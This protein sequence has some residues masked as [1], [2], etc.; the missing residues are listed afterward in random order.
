MSQLTKVFRYDPK[1][2]SQ[3]ADALTRSGYQFK[4][5]AYAKF[6]ARG[7]GV[8]I[9][10]YNS[11]KVV[12]QGQ[13]PEQWALRYLGNA[14]EIVKKSSEDKAKSNGLLETSADQSSIGS[15]EAGKGDSFGGLVVSAV[16]LS[17]TE[18]LAIAKA[19]VGDSKELSDERIRVLAPWIRSN[20]DWAEAAL[21]PI[22]YNQQR[23][24]CSENVNRLLSK[25][26]SQLQSELHSKTGI[27]VSIVDRFSAAN[28]VTQQLRRTCPMVQVIEVPKAE[29]YAA[30]AA[31]SVLARESFLIM[32]EKLSAEWAVSLPLGSGSPVPKALRQFLR[33]HGP[34]KLALVAKTHFKNVQLIA[35]E[36]NWK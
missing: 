35:G 9:S 22:Q 8:T 25:L 23:Y 2:S 13:A 19:G 27:G 36:Q 30:V 12:V 1:R 20:F 29:R 7:E 34:S 14:K 3:L 6:Q 28:P 5:L 16:A 26:H 10:F 31:A 4:E 15:D 21:E 33:I 24:E 18:L 32:M 17:E 11:G